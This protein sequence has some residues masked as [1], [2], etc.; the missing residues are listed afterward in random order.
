MIKKP[1]SIRSSVVAHWG[2]FAAI[3][4]LVVCAVVYPRARLQLVEPSPDNSYRLEHYRPGLAFVLYYRHVK[5]MED[6]AFVR[7]YR[8]ADNEFFG[9]SPV[10]DFF[11]GEPDTYWDIERTGE[12][13]LGASFVFSGVPPVQGGEAAAENG[14]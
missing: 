14:D 12:V 10:L 8:N 13:A 2:K 5:G 1:F 7:L 3:A 11:G 6:P 9:E 4:L